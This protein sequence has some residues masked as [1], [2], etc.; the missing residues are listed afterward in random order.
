MD[1]E[2]VGAAVVG[3][4]VGTGVI[5]GILV[6]LEVQMRDV[7][8]LF[9]AV[10]RFVGLPGQ[11][12]LGFVIYSLAGAVVWPLIFLAL[13]PYLPRGPDPAAQ[14][15]VFATALWVVFAITGRGDLT[16]PLLVV[17]LVFT[18]LAHWAYGFTMGAVYGYLTGETPRARGEP[19]PR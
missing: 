18:L 16:G 8:H 9:D 4:V 14:G 2:Q 5:S 7:L 19:A 6:M 1:R 3:G 13:R 10:A 11:T 15:T 12:F 17:Y